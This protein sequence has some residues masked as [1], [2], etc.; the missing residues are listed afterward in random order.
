MKKI[1]RSISIN[2]PI[3][4]AFSYMNQPINQLEW[5][6]GLYKIQDI[7]GEGVGQTCSWTYK[8]MGIPFKGKAECMEHIPNERIVIKTTGSIKSIWD[9]TL[10]PQGGMTSVNLVVDYTIPVPLIGKLGEKLISCQNEHEADLVMTKIKKSLEYRS[11][12]KIHT[13]YSVNR[14]HLG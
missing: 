13:K 6:P 9:F 11:Q 1:E 8:M 7:K 3:E 5:L 12:F 2:I 4:K 14:K 10:I